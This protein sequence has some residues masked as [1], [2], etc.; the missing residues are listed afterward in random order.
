M[1]KDDRASTQSSRGPFDA[2]LA[3]FPAVRASLAASVSLGLLS[4]AGIVAQALG[5]AHLLASA[6][7][8]AHPTDRLHWFILLASGFALRA[9]AA[10]AGDVV[11]A[12]GTSAVKADL[13][14][15]LVTAVLSPPVLAPEHAWASAGSSVAPPDSRAA[16]QAPAGA[17][18]ATP[19]GMPGPGEVATLA[20]RGLDALDVYIGRC[21]PDLVLAVAAPLVLLVAVGALDWVSVIVMGAVLALFPVFGTLVGQA[22]W[23]LG[24][25]RWQRVEQL[26]NYVADIFQGMPLLR[27]FGRSA[28]QRERIAELNKALG[29]STTKALRVAFLSALVL[30]TLGSLSVALVAVPLGLRLISGGIRLAPALAVLAVAPEVFAPLRKA[31]AEFHEST[32]GLAAAT[33]VLEVVG[34]PSTPR[35][36]ARKA[37]RHGVANP[38]PVGN[39][40]V[41]LRSVSVLLPGRAVPVLQDA[42]LV[43]EPG[44]KVALV[45][46]S[47]AGKSTV[48]ALLAGFARPSS[49]TVFAGDADL[50]DL[51][52]RWWRSQVT[53]LPEHPSVLSTT[54]RENLRLANPSATDQQLLSGLNQAGAP[55][56]ARSLP[57]GL[58]A[59][60]GEGGRALSAGE[61][62]R[63]ALARVM[64]RPARL[65][66]LDEPT[67][68]LDQASEEV[69]LTGLRRAIGGA[70]ALIVSHKPAVARAADR[71]LT[72]RAGKLIELSS[73]ELAEA[74]PA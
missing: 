6:M 49:G 63:V 30:D 69:A 26:G 25:E 10:L 7:P 51:D 4:T 1:P 14:A 65:Y 20:G 36:G 29:H 71:V 21:L 73:F 38:A 57:G 19:A 70:S 47:G 27:A 35:Q 67:V 34:E 59:Q 2:R 50:R 56:L 5:L 17:P 53:Y 62:Q 44:E 23:A 74:V 33:E 40:A 37:D 52:L 3:R 64:L 48:I 39:H 61:L 55:E 8:G 45:G 24:A 66:L 15:R 16:E 31:S 12:H 54:L 68:H 60:L 42:D 46:P 28:A 41:G 22:S 13:R 11:A 43:I 32:E 18:Q 72:L 9:L 58:D